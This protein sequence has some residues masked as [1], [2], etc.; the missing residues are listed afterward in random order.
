MAESPTGL[1]TGMTTE[2][3]KTV[4]FEKS[5]VENQ[6]EIPSQKMLKIY[7]KEKKF[8]KKKERKKKALFKNT[9]FG[10]AYIYH[11]PFKNHNAY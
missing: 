11:S 6:Y 2:N 7:S 3:S 8:K 5:S 1:T 4:F 10:K 9:E